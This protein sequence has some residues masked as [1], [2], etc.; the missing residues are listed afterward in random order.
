M[1]LKN[2]LIIGTKNET[3]I[4]YEIYF[5]IRKGFLPN[6]LKEELS[7]NK[8]VPSG[9]DRLYFFPGCTIPRFKIREKFKVTIK[10]KTA[11][12]L[13]ISPQNLTSVPDMCDRIPCATVPQKVVIE[14]LNE[15]YG[16]EHYQTIKIKS[17]L[18]N[19]EDDV[20]IAKD[21]YHL[22]YNYC[23]AN[24]TER[25]TRFYQIENSPSIYRLNRHNEWSAFYSFHSNWQNHITVSI[26]DETE[27][28]NIINVDKLIVDKTRYEEF[29]LM[30]NSSD[31]ND[32]ILMMEMMANSDYEKS[33]VYLLSLLKEFGAKFLGKETKKA[34][35]HVNFKS[36]LVYF[37]IKN[38]ENLTLEECVN[39]MRKQ[40]KFTRSNIQMITQ[41]FSNHFNSD[42]FK[43]GPVLKPE[44]EKYLDDDF[45]TD[46]EEVQIQDEEE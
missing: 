20:I 28:L 14:Y 35:Q 34:T 38:L 3:G 2:Y 36:L 46:G 42:F 32:K 21:D 22:L 12:A 30:G 24:V 26:Y 40:R 15:L 18:L 37:Q 44:A 16:E 4:D 6:T 29:R 1:Q 19:C 43:Q 13:F 45:V 25:W 11:T 33:F 7:E 39:I 23:P 27:I 5:Q 8:W 31:P 9:N 17:I 41:H 10:P